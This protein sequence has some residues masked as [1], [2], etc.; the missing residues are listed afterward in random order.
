MGLKINQETKAFATIEEVG[1]AIILIKKGLIEIL[2]MKSHK[3]S[4][5]KHIPLLLLS[6]GFERLLK[7]ILIFQYFKVNYVFPTEIG[8]FFKEY[9]NGHGL[10]LMLN[11][12]I[13]IA[14]SSE[15]M[16]SIPLSRREIEYLENEAMI[17]ELF[18]IFSDYAISGRY[19]HI[20]IITKQDFPKENPILAFEKF[21]EDIYTQLNYSI[22]EFWE[23][24]DKLNEQ[25]I[26]IIARITKALCLCF[27]H[28]D[29]GY[30]ASMHSDEVFEFTLLD[31]KDLK[32]MKYLKI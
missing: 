20:D 31:E 9:R 7:C 26:Y 5:Y 8:N 2:N 3:S 22:N 10:D 18:K 13:R 23:N 15:T 29:F 32:I 6:N 24:S 27:T 28:A 21:R 30:V 25:N 12:V 14:K 11:E 16:M 1:A 4:V 17:E 19:Y